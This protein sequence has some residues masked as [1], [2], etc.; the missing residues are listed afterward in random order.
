MAQKNRVNMLADIVTNIYTNIVNFITG[1]NAQERLINLLDSTPNI[2]SDKNQ[3][4]G[5][6]GTNASN[7]KIT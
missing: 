2:L 1:N 6:V 5:Y 3:A 7:M 4:D